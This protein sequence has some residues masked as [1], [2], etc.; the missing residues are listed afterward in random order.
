MPARIAWSVNI[1]K[2]TASNNP[3]WESELIRRLAAA[4]PESL[5]P[6]LGHKELFHYTTAEGLKGIIENNCLWATSASYLNDASEIEYGCNLLEEVFTDW[7]STRSKTQSLGAEVMELVR[8]SFNDPRSKHERTA[9]IYVACFCEKDNL[10]SQ[11]RAYGQAGGYSVGFSMLSRDGKI[12]LLRAENPDFL[13]SLV[14]VI[15][16]RMI[17]AQ[18]LH[19]ILTDIFS[20]LDQPSILKEAEAEG[21]NGKVKV[22]HAGLVALEH[23]L[24]EEISAFKNAAFQEEQEWRIVARPKVAKEFVGLKESADSSWLHFRVMRGLMVPYIKLVPTIPDWILP[25]A[26]VRLGP[27]LDKARAENSVAMLLL[28]NR[29]KSFKIHGSEIPVLL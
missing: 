29:Y 10:L 22:Y 21:K 7:H 16:D 4:K 23:Y 18:R 9:G 11:W 3:D 8:R 25:I 14:P 5:R 20:I 24:M 27:S 12:N 28:R 15:Y 1:I 2:V 6:A 26:S 13:I 17:Q 19:R